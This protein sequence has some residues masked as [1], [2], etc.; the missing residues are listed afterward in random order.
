VAGALQDFA[1]AGGRVARGLWDFEFV[2]APFF[3]VGGR[4]FY[5]SIQRFHEGAQ[6][7]PTV[8]VLHGNLTELILVGEFHR[9]RKDR[10][11]PSRSFS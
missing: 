1:F 10:L 3:G 5:W 9:R 8:A 2:G 11:G 4:G 7:Q 6:G